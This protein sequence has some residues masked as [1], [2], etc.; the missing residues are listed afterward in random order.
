MQSEGTSLQDVEWLSWGAWLSPALAAQTLAESDQSCSMAAT[1]QAQAVFTN[2]LCTDAKCRAR[3]P[4]RQ[5]SHSQTG[6]QSA[7]WQW[8]TSAHL[9]PATICFSI[10]STE[11]PNPSDCDINFSQNHCFLTARLACSLMVSIGAAAERK[12]GPLMPGYSDAEL[13]AVVCAD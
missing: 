6:R 4:C 12:R 1:S 13:F 3:F 10:L 7:V 11:T 9:P 5:T 8:L 2:S